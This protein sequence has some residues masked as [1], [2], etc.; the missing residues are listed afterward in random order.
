MYRIGGAY[1][2]SRKF[3]PWMTYL[4]DEAES[5]KDFAIRTNLYENNTNFYPQGEDLIL[6][7][8]DR[9][10]FKSVENNIMLLNKKI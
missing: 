10:R 5:M 4:N 6:W 1:F 8:K 9:R 2:K 3:F 7:L